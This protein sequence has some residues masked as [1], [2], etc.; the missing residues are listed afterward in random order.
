MERKRGARGRHDDRR[1][2]L[3]V[4]DGELLARE[5]DRPRLRPRD[6]RSSPGFRGRRV[7]L[8]GRG[9]RQ[10]GGE[11]QGALRR[12]VRREVVRARG[13]ARRG[14]RRR[15]LLAR[16]RGRRRPPAGCGAVLRVEVTPVGSSRVDCPPGTALQDD[17]CIALVNLECPAGLH[18][19][20]GAGGRIPSLAPCPA[21]TTLR[22]D[23]CVRLVTAAVARTRLWSRR[24]RRT[25]RRRPR[26][27]PWPRHPLRPSTR[28][29]AVPHGTVKDD[30]I[31]PGE[32]LFLAGDYP[33][34]AAY[35]RTAC[36]RG[37]AFSCSAAGRML[38]EGQGGREGHGRRARAPFA[39][40]SRGRPVGV[41]PPRRAARPPHLHLRGRD[42]LID[43]AAF[44]RKACAM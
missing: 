14:R 38:A 15:G 43:R 23:A 13:Q 19:D 35:F 25:T 29:P 16:V 18:F 10:G 21:G 33:A 20:E 24:S 2:L 36:D 40:V 3:R 26:R 22:G 34:A 32:E 39:R 5:H 41:L 44:R 12:G 37:S 30:A 4:V 28:D 42:E 17:R 31:A 27:R 9:R 8:Q 11:R 6:P 1:A 7:R